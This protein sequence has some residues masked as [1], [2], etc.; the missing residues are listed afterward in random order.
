VAR[1]ALDATA[2]D[3]ARVIVAAMQGFKQSA[4]SSEE[5]RHLIAV[6]VLAIE[7]A[8]AS[9]SRSGGR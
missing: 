9:S 7:R 6:Q 3:L 8:L 2:A 4:Q 1:S 5:M